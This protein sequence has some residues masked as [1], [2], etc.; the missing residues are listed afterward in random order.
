[1]QAWIHS[2]GGK[3]PIVLITTTESF[4]ERVYVWLRAGV[5]M[6]H[7]AG[8]RALLAAACW[9]DD[10]Y[11]AR[12]ERFAHITVLDVIRRPSTGPAE[13]DWPDIT[14]PPSWPQAGS[15]HRG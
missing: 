10:V 15:M 5:S 7:L 6:E 9:A 11:V 12:H 13:H 8:A 14:E 1:M 3:I 2:R 4:G